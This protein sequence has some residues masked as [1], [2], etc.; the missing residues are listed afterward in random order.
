MGSRQG[1]NCVIKSIKVHIQISS[2]RLPK[3]SWGKVYF[4]VRSGRGKR[5]YIA[6]LKVEAAP[7]FKCRR[8]QGKSL[9][10]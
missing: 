9:P 4:T 2:R 1:G 6:Y 8:S 3:A 7:K 10:R 5:G